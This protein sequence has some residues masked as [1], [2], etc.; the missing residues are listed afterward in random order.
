MSKL[1]PIGAFFLL[2]AMGVAA[3]YG[4]LRR[5]ELEMKNWPVTPAKIIS[6]GIVRTTTLRVHIDQ[7]SDT[8]NNRHEEIIN[9][10]AIDVQYQAGGR[11]RYGLTAS[12]SILYDVIRTGKEEPS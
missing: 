2:A 10:W 11:Q 1:T 3:F 9:V 6:S 4:F 7:S 5:R 12:S 8:Q